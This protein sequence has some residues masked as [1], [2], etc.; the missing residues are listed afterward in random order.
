MNIEGTKRV[1]IENVKPQI[2]GGFFPIK[3]VVDEKVVVE[4]DIFV[5]GRDEITARLLYR[6][7]DEKDWHQ[8][9]MQLVVNDHWQAVFEVRER[10]IYYYTLQAL[11]DH[12]GT[13]RKDLK[14]K[15]EAGQEI[16]VDLLMGIELI[17]HILK[18]ASKIEVEKLKLWTNIL[19]D[20][21]QLAEGVTLALSDEWA[22]IF[23]K[24][25]DKSLAVTFEKELTVV[26]DR[27]KA[28]FSSW[29][30]LFPRSCGTAPGKQGT[31]K[32]CHAL[33]PHIGKMGFDV[34]Y[35]PPI[36][37]IGKTKRKGKNNTITADPKSMGSPWAIGSEA[38]GHKSIDP[39]LGTMKDFQEFVKQADQ[40]GLEVALDLAFQCSPDHPYVKEHPEW[41]KKRPDGTIQYAENPPKKY[42]DIVPLNF[43][44]E[45]WQKLWEELK[46]IV[47]FWIDKGV[48]IFR[49]DNPHTKPFAFWEW[50]ISEIKKDYPDTIFLSEAFTRPKVMYRLAKAGFTQSYTYFTWRNT[51]AEITNYLRELTQTE[52]REYFRP[53]FWPNTPDILPEFLQYDGRTSFIIRL[54]LAATLSSSYGIYGPAYELCVKE[55][56][57]GKEE[58]RDSEKYEVKNWD[59]EME[60]NLQDLI[61]RL[62][63]IRKENRA[64]QTTRNLKFYEVDNEYLLFYGKATEDLNNIILIVVNLDPYHTQSGW[65]KV[66]RNELQIDPQQTYLVH[67]LLSDDKYIWH[68][69]R[70]YVELNPQI[71]PVHI[72]KVKRR[73]RKEADFDYYM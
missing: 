3:R 11:V 67:D 51:K 68:G 39:S 10:G 34:L 28:L 7:S 41:F 73:L 63:R 19:K 57:E 33:L 31:F 40:F 26:V 18:K 29:Y 24:Y 37:P 32:D 1:I 72:L 21:K 22:E 8:V 71:V 52:I 16:R 27:Q 15:Y 59:V 50:L 70:N 60:G 53:N 12:I 56:L 69:E 25:S 2:D 14:K 61:A 44:T 38:G 23:R 13:W 17:E 48:R 4:A 9:P 5:D 49:V 36:H 43:E 54:V 66:P 64:L 6:K 30:E 62:N 45:N 46:S 42:E 47:L 58:Y 65:V 35:F 55:A 20:E